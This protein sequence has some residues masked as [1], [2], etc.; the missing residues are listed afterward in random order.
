MFDNEALAYPFF[1]TTRKDSRQAPHPVYLRDQL[2]NFELTMA[3]AELRIARPASAIVNMPPPEPVSPRRLLDWNELLK[4]NVDHLRAGD[5]LS[6]T[7]RPPKEDIYEGNR[8]WVEPGQTDIEFLIFRTVEKYLAICARSHIKLADPVR[9]SLPEGYAGRANFSIS[10]SGMFGY[11]REMNEGH[12]WETLHDE[13]RSRIP[14]FVMRCD[15]LW[16]GGPGAFIAFSMDSLST[17]AWCWHLRRGLSHL[18]TQP[19]FHFYE[20]TPEAL[21]ERPTDPSWAGRWGVEPV[22]AMPPAA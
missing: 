14:A 16:E 20:M 22:V 6:L 13:R 8:M 18:L 21:P 10:Q 19:G 2:A 7:T 9:D 5:F 4:V 12:G 3:I 15:E 17:A 11:Y 1:Y